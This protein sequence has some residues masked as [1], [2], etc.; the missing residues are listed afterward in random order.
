MVET[1]TPPT[2]S[3]PPGHS[4]SSLC[5]LCGDTTAYFCREESPE[6]LRTL[7]CSNCGLMYASP[8][9]S[10]AEVDHLNLINRGDQGS[11]TRSP[12]GLLSDRDLR[13]EE[14]FSDWAFKVI[15]RV[16]SVP[17]KSVLTLRCRS[18]SL[19]VRLVEQ[20]AN[21]CAIDSYEANVRHAREQRGL[22]A[23]FLVPM[24]RFHDLVPPCGSPFDMVVG[25]NEHVLAH[26]MS[27]RLLLGRMFD[28]LKPGGHLFLEEKDVLLPAPHLDAFVLDSGQA[29]LFHLT[30]ET[31]ARY[32]RAAGFELIECEIDEDRI[33]DYKHLRLVARKPESAIASVKYPPIVLEAPGGKETLR[34]VQILE[35]AD[36]LKKRRRAMNVRA[37]QLLKRIPG[38]RQA[39]HVA[40]RLW[41][42]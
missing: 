11:P 10:P 15:Q 40:Q 8:Q 22:A 31:T 35:R 34:R 27:P 5:D 3:M 42:H 38:L 21:V 13:A 17:G 23:T 9:P 33:S 1:V 29:H 32:V 39:W 37:R 16:V 41:R 12:S 14:H 25:L 24:S 2:G 36:R 28:L 6:K 19:S 4:L 20:G 7:V 26:V 18:G 30:L